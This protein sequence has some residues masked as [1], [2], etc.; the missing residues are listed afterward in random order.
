MLQNTMAPAAYVWDLAQSTING[1]IQSID[2]LNY[3]KN[4]ADSI[5][6]YLGKFQDVSYYK[7]SPC[8]T[9]AGC[10]ATERKAMER[11][12]ALASESQKKANALLKGIKAQQDNLQADTRQLERL[13]TT[14]QGQ[15]ETIQ[16]ANQFASQQNNQLLQIHGLLL[17]QQNAIGAQMQAQ[18]DREAQLN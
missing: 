5:D 7:S 15:M 4:Q 12:R 6:A 18:A 2:S 3:Y 8:F 10:S 14:A 17:A 9:A 13:Q 11:N 1:L 16:Y